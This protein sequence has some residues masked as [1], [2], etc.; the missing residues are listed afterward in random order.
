MG[1]NR[2][3]M[4]VLIVLFLGDIELFFGEEG[5]E[6][7]ESHSVAHIIR[8]SS[9]DLNDLEQRGNTFHLRGADGHIP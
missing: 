6:V 9:V 8:L 3:M 5:C 1:E 7:L 2:S 4:R